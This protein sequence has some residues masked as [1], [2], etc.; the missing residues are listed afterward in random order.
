MSLRLS[1]RAVFERVALVA[2]L[3]GLGGTALAALPVVAA[4]ADDAEPAYVTL[5]T[6]ATPAP[7]TSVGP[8]GTITFTYTINCSSDVAGCVDLQVSNELPDPLTLENVSMS[9]SSAQGS[10]TTTADSF[11]LTFT[12]DLGG[13]QVGLPDGFSVE[14]LATAR[15]P[16]DVSADFD[17]DVLVNEAFATL[18]YSASNTSDSA[19]VLLEVPTVLASTAA[20]AVTPTTVDAV[21]GREV[22]YRLEGVNTSN[23]AV[24]ELLLQFPADPATT[25]SPFASVAP[26]G[27]TVAAWP[28]GADR[29]RVDWYDG[30]TWHP[31]SAATTA[32]L[33]TP[34]VGQQLVALRL[35]FTRADGSRLASGAE[36]EVELEGA[37]RALVADLVSPLTITA[38]ASSWVVLA[39]AS[40]TPGSASASLRIDPVSVSPGATRTVAPDS[41]VGGKDVEVT[42]RAENG[43]DFSLGSLTITEPAPGEPALAAQGLEFDAWVGAE[44]EWPVGATSATA[45]Y[46]YDGDAGFTAAGTVSRPAAL[47]APDGARVVNAVRV[48]F[49]GTM[50]PGQYASLSYA[51]HTAV[52]VADTT[53]TGT[54]S[55][56]AVTTGASPLS[57]STTASDDLTRRTARVDARA[58]ITATPSALYGV[59]GA[60]SVLSIVG[61]VAPVPTSP[62]DTGGSTVGASRLVVTDPGAGGDFW[63]SFALSRIVATD[64]PAGSRLTV[65]YRDTNGTWA[66]LGTPTTGPALFSHTL[67]TGE[68]SALV[69]LR[70]VYEPDGQAELPPGFT[71]SIGLRVALLAAGIDAD[72]VAPY[73]LEN[74]VDV[75]VESP[76][77][78]PGSASADDDALLTITPVDANG[79]GSGLEL[80]G[81]AWTDDVVNARSGADTT[82]TISWGTGGLGFDSVVLADGAVDPDEPGFDVADTAFEAF[83]LVRIPAIT[84]GMD[85]LLTY[86][87]ITAVE[88][89]V[90]GSGWVP[91]S[92]NPCAGTACDGGFPGYTLT[93]S[94]RNAA[95]GVRLVVEESP[96]RAARVD[97]TDP[98]APPVGSGVAASTELDRDLRLVFR[99]RDARR[100]DGDPVLG[101]S[102]GMTYNTAAAGEVLNSARVDGRLAGVTAQ[103]DEADDIIQILD[104]PLNVTATK[105]WTGGPLGVPADGTPAQLFPHARMT[106]GATNA[107]VVP[108][109]ELALSEPGIVGASTVPDPFEAVDIT[110]IVSISVPS[111]ATSTTVVLGPSNTSYTVAEAL[112]L[113]TAQLADATSIEIVHAGRIAAGAATQVVLD[114]RLREHL[115]SDPGT[116]A[117]VAVSP[118]ANSVRARVSDL[119]GLWAG[120]PEDAPAP[121]ATMTA[122][123]AATAQLALAT[124]EV[125]VV[126]TKLVTAGTAATDTEPAIQYDG[127]ATTATVSLRGQPAGNVRYTDLVLEDTSP[128]FWNAYAF[129]GFASHS[130]AAPIDRVQVDALVDVTYVAESDGSIGTTGGTWEEGVPRT[131]LALPAGVLPADVRGL[132]V[133]YLRADGAV[134]ERP[135][136]PRQTATFTVTRRTDLLTGGPV[137]STLYIHAPGIAPGETERA[138]FTNELEATVSARVAAGG[139]ALWT[140]TDDDTK[141]LR[142][143][144]L[145][146]KAEIRVSPTGSIALG[147]TIA[148]DIDV[149]NTGSTGDRALSGVVVTALLPVDGTGSPLLVFPQ[150]PDTDV[151]YD[152]NTPAD[153]AHLFD[154]ELRNGSGTPQPAPSVGV[155]LDTVDVGGV[156]HP[157]LT[158]TV[159]GSIPLGG[160]LTIGADLEFRPQLEAGTPVLVSTTVVSDQ[161]FDTCGRHYVDA[162]EVAPGSLGSGV[163]PYT[164]TESCFS[165]TTVTPLP[166]APLTVVKGVKG[167]AAGPLDASGDPMLDGGG[168]PYSDLGVAAVS[169]AGGVDCSAPNTTITVNGGG[170]YRYPCVPITR[171]GATEEWAATFT[172][173]GNVSVRQVVAIDLLPRP[174]DTGVTIPT[175]RGSQWTARLSSY[176]VAH[177]LPVGASLEVYATSQAGMATARCN[178]ADIQSTMG[179]T[180]TSS[181]PMQSSYQPCLANTAASDDLPDRAWSLL[182]NDPDAWTTVVALKFVVL[183]DASS[184]LDDL[185]GPGGSISVT[186]RTTTALAPEI[187]QTAPQ[188]ALDPVAYNSIAAAATGRIY[189]SG[190]PL[191]LAYRLVTEPRKAGVALA[192]GEL[193][194][195]K[196][197]TGAAASY[198]PTSVSVALACTVDVDGVPIPVQLLDSARADRSSVTLTPGTTRL[199]QGIPLYASCTATEA[200][201]YGRTSV[202]TS[203]SPS[204]IAAQAGISMG[205]RPVSNPHP[206]FGAGTRPAIERATITNTYSAAQLVVS[207]TVN[208]NGAVNHNG[209]AIAYTAPVF[210]VSCRFDNGVTNPV[211]LSATNVT[212]AAGASVTFPRV[213]DP[214]LPAGSVCT[215][216]ET[217]TRNATTTQHTVTTAAGAGSLTTGTSATVTLTADGPGSTPTNSAA[218]LN[219]YGVGSLTVTKSIAGLGAARYGTGDF[220]VQVTCTRSSATPS[221][222]VWSG[223][224]TLDAGSPT[225]TIEN[226]PA[227]AN[228][229]VTEPSAAGATSTTFS[230]SNGQRTIPNGSAGAVTITNTFDLARIAITKDVRTDAVDQDG[231][232]VYP[233]DTFS[234]DV[235]CTFQGA[236][237]LADGFASSPMHVTGVGRG[238]TRTLTGLPAGASCVVAEVA[239]ATEVDSTSIAWTTSSTSGSA[240]SASATFTLTRDTSATVGTN[241]VTVVNRYDVTALTVTKDV[242]GAAGAQFGAGPFRI[243]VECVA[244]GGVTA[245]DGELTLPTAG[246]AWFRTIED[247]PDGAECSVEE[248]GA[249]ATG[250]D[251]VRYLDADGDE[252][253]GTGVVVAT[254]DPGAVTIENWYLTGAVTVTK[255]TDGDGSPDYGS[256]RFEIELACV[257]DVGGTE[258]AV[259]GYP[260]TRTL[261]AGDSTTFTGLA[262]GAECT[263]TET[264]AAGATA[265]RIESGGTVLT[266]DATAGY[267]FTVVVDPDD[268]VDDQAQPALEVVNLFQL[269]A[270]VVTK[271]VQSDAVDQDGDAIRYGPFPV[272]ASCTFEG[273]PVYATGY[274]ATTPM[275]HVFAQGDP[276][277]VLEGLVVGA[278]C[279]VVETDRGS[280]VASRIT[281]TPSGG[282]TSTS[283]ASPSSPSVD[284]TIVLARRAPGDAENTAAIRNDYEAGTVSI[285]KELAG[286]GTA[287]AT[288]EFAIEV[289]CVLADGPV[290]ATVWEATYVVDAADLAIPD[291]EHVAAGAECDVTETRTG[292]AT[293]TVV[294]VGPDVIP[295]TAATFTSP[296]GATVAVTVTNVFDAG[297]VVV[298]KDRVG[299]ADVLARYGVGPFEVEL[300]CTRVVDG[301]TL[302]VDIPGGATRTLDATGMFEATFAS[303]PVGAECDVTETRTGGATRSTVSALALP[304]AV[305]ANDVQLVNEFADGSVAVTKT[306]A[307]SGA[308]LYGTGPFYVTLECTRDVDGA[309]VPVAIPAPAVPIPG[310]A[311]PAVRELSAANGYV[312]DYTGL[313]T[314]ADC[315]IA[316]TGTGGALEV[317]IDVPEFTIGDGTSQPV[318]I[319]NTFELVALTVTNEVT[320]NAA[321]PKMDADFVI[322]LECGLDVN[323]TPTDLRIVDGAERTFKHAGAVEYVDLPAGAECALTETDDHGAD[324][325]RILQG[326]REVELFTLGLAAEATEIQVVNTFVKLAATGSTP[327]LVAYLA[328]SLFAL[329]GVLAVLGG[330]RTARHRA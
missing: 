97:E 45:S 8:G 260:V 141:Q 36:A 196:Q 148:Y 60:S 237:V 291:L 41:V 212:I 14:F 289:V 122:E 155:V 170:Y 283:L 266:G 240:S 34:G 262:S 38:A 12:N 230:P 19:E 287:W 117:D 233:V 190:N 309:M 81:K 294:T 191:D 232:P 13:G 295:G 112:A 48:V 307:G 125:G 46:R 281:T 293:S 165:T 178:G 5:V 277:W 250:A 130:F 116:R 185:L 49:T 20:H 176:P 154:V 82:A 124:A 315:A 228:C 280:A 275:T 234:F 94:E 278:E 61:R 118:V 306:L 143:E 15:V 63:E 248:L 203:P 80:V 264:D 199:V 322:E 184:G 56:D 70:F 105:S 329:G 2:A 102:R 246:G 229:T 222:T 216:T 301:T 90:P 208:T 39:S 282:S 91:T 202:V 209:V 326:G 25:P 51:A 33:P 223:S 186:Y 87:R 101:T 205:S 224:F 323:G 318:G 213:T 308:A 175:S 69:G 312:V 157:R 177:G 206:A 37:L 28:G 64:V 201:D 292:G 123:H 136:N 288:E 107:T 207:K 103:S 75:T 128:T 284:A 225:R 126:A 93:T 311:D 127:S 71:V 3:A 134:W 219:T 137:P 27:I 256:G 57:A 150:N 156:D 296:A 243:A 215:V 238:A 252:F 290:D 244:P 303:L 152:P 83:D 197:N 95:V 313:P 297:D 163:P 189:E 59:P 110:D 316:E 183:M 279:E 255:S 235:T 1:A 226:L 147:D 21:S 299:D 204:T 133:T 187:G 164:F 73:V 9:S 194:L 67:G 85:P 100:S 182:P 139:A 263:L 217:N 99:L 179:M 221:T 109:A 259:T 4:A 242:Q 53:V 218:F 142:Y 6:S 298:T 198:A 68:R 7:P 210:S 271:T 145:P 26:G 180:P 88:L 188:L 89:Y 267:T 254:G 17:G 272:E 231:D 192:V 220:T 149:R 247:L 328:L 321:E 43:G 44:L 40:S 58:L 162:G 31:G 10:F 132:R 111:G 227:A 42:L 258:V 115:R 114:T 54:M 11:V 169:T 119:G 320:G 168:E 84:S 98:L 167:I 330:R 108:V 104:R 302:A 135:F 138:T 158:F 120:D 106:L 66:T 261:E 18:A 325:V 174:D 32:V 166:S 268:L 161:E 273:S 86:D 78:S 92:T 257:R 47:P 77:A 16:G 160:T 200:D 52:V 236:A 140:A 23:T 29:V 35:A 24:D 131:S 211:I 74:V 96:T 146:A 72:A 50:A 79:P 193:E 62:S 195:L 113:T 300:V 30:T 251:A 274:D 286:D 181:P 305:G 319:T 171:P 317:E 144:H 159:G 239:I 55:V 304:L 151:R 285:T 173:S 76:A 269:A 249:A 172:N 121:G 153:A 22:V 214:V 265:T 327:L 65:E 253:D 270:L 129:T 241:A 324:P 310:V 276:A 245:Y 314:G